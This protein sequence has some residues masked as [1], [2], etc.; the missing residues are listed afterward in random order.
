MAS[1][2]PTAKGLVK[3][4]VLTNHQIVINRVAPIHTAVELRQSLDR[5]RQIQSQVAVVHQDHETRESLAAGGQEA[6]ER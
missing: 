2:H 5:F 6:K 1:L 3:A 4:V